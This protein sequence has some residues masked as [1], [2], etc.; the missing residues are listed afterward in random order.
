M[1]VQYDLLL[2]YF[3]EKA[4]IRNSCLHVC[5]HMHLLEC[6]V[7]VG[8]IYSIFGDLFWSYV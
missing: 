5:A 2:C 1:A 7:K 6:G 4:I 8:C 3:A